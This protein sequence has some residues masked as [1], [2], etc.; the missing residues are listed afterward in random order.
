[1]SFVVIIAL[2]FAEKFEHFFPFKQWEIFN[3]G[4][5][6][7]KSVKL[8]TLIA[9]ISGSFLF[10][11]LCA[12]TNNTFRFINKRGPLIF[13]EIF[14]LEPSALS[15]LMHSYHLAICLHYLLENFICPLFWGIPGSFFS[16]FSCFG[17]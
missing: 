7:N 13:L 8:L 16:L 17:G 9:L 6:N 12:I 1:M 2:G 11:F 15:D 5:N 10:N 14:P 3:Q 4:C